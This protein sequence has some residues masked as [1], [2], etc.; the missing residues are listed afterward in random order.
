M[1]NPSKSQE[2][3]TQIQSQS[4]RKKKKKSLSPLVLITK[5]FKLANVNI[6]HGSS[7]HHHDAQYRYINNQ[8]CKLP[9]LFSTIE[10]VCTWD[11]GL[12][13]FE[14]KKKKG[15]THLQGRDKEPARA[16]LDPCCRSW[17]KI[18]TRERRRERYSE[19]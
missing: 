1:S 7:S 12:G 9:E 15:E 17:S 3:M 19:K 11:L 13:F 4:N 18:P 5:F 10:L 14:K 8:V 6:Q 16:G 2:T